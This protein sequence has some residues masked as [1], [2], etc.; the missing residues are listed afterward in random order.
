MYNNCLFVNI[1]TK[2]NWSTRKV[3]KLMM[4]WDFVQTTFFHLTMAVLNKYE[5]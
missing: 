1:T 5:F 4:S 2:Q 3:R